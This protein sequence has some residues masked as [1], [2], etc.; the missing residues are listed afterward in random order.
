MAHPNALAAIGEYE[1]EDSNSPPRKFVKDFSNYFAKLLETGEQ[2]DVTVIV[3]GRE[4]RVH[5]FVLSVRSSVFRTMLDIEMKEKREN[6]VVIDDFEHDVMYELFTFMYTLK[7]PNLKHLSFELLQAADKYGLLDLKRKCA[8]VL[9]ENITT[10]TA[11]SILSL[12]DR[13][14]EQ[15]LK[16]LATDF[17]MENSMECALD[18]NSELRKEFKELPASILRELLIRA[19]NKLSPKKGV[20]IN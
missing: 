5:Q 4:I 2:S 17:I 15:T 20:R 7:T 3:K 9:E 11:A 13:C 8:K 18:E 10:Q 1:S 12:A 14:D 16:A 19:F 6:I